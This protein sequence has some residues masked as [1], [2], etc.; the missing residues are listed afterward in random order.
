MNDRFV[1]L[2]TCAR[3][4][5]VPRQN[6]RSAVVAHLSRTCFGKDR[7]A[8]LL[9]R[10]ARMPRRTRSPSSDADPLRTAELSARTFCTFAREFS[11][12]SRQG[13]PQESDADPGHGSGRLRGRPNDPLLTGSLL[14][15]R[16]PAGPVVGTRSALPD[17]AAAS[18]E[19]HVPQTAERLASTRARVRRPPVTSGRPAP[20]PR[21]RSTSRQA[22][23]RETPNG[24]ARGCVPG[25]RTRLI[26]EPW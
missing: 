2:R 1:C 9:N 3:D 5:I 21:C 18:I 10:P 12:S 13:G 23:V 20:R 15:T 14:Q 11:S 24:E 7:R 25:H 19:G 8:T 22:S 16:G 6:S 4:T 17:Q 26:A